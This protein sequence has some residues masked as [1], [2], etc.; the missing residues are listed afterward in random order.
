MQKKVAGLVTNSAKADPHLQVK[1][2][3]ALAVSSCDCSGLGLLSNIT[4]SLRLP[5]TRNAE[6]ST[7]ATTFEVAVERDARARRQLVVSQRRAAQRHGLQA[8]QPHVSA[9]RRGRA[10]RCTPTAAPVQRAMALLL[11]LCVS[12]AAATQASVS[13][14]TAM[15][16]TK[17]KEEREW[18]HQCISTYL[19]GDTAG[20]SASDIS[21][22]LPRAAAS[23]GDCCRKS[24]AVE[25][26][27]A[28][29]PA[30]ASG[31]SAQAT[32]IAH[33]ILQQPDTFM[34]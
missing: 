9:G 5:C 34:T 23:A 17:V 1:N 20:R 10:D 18:Q 16:D 25:S 4:H 29:T 2:N 32:G 8:P 12:G 15:N 30:G 33:C 19:Q 3:W 22:E 13:H 28:L 31:A 26:G 11:C 6:Q 21:G 7:R 24:L 14:I 27:C